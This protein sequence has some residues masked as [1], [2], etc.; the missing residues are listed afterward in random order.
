MLLDMTTHSAITYIDLIRPRTASRLAYNV[1]LVAIGSVS[2]A[3]CAQIAIPLPFT[4]VPLTGQTFAVLLIG[5]IYG[6]RLGAA[7]VL[8]YLA[9]GAIGLPF[10]AGGASGLAVFAGPTAGYL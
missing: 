4:P 6:S 1:L 5:I 9:E 8:A 10:F 3:A 2:I 7:T